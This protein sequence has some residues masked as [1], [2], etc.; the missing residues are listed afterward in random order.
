[1]N[2]AEDSVDEPSIRSP[3]APSFHDSVQENKHPSCV[4]EAECGISARLAP[5]YLGFRIRVTG[6]P[7][8]WRKGHV[9][10][11]WVGQH[12]LHTHLRRTALMSVNVCDNTLQSG[13]CLHVR[14]SEPL[15]SVHLC[16]HQD[17]PAMSADS[18]RVRLFFKRQSN[19]ALPGDSNRD[20]HQYSL[21]PSAVCCE[22][23]G[24][25]GFGK[26]RFKSSKL[27]RLNGGEHQ[28][29]ALASSGVDDPRL[30][31]K[32]LCPLRDAYVRDCP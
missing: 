30:G 28:P 31:F 27:L 18:P 29:H 32:Q 1:M 11:Y 10:E 25:A 21:T 2:G 14:Q 19:S 15:S 26:P 20:C 4:S 22:P 23:G 8:F 24:L 5:C 16:R 7:V 3:P 12:E 13:F 17:Q 6:C 9:P